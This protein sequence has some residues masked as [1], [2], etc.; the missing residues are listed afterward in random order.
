MIV[1]NSRENQKPKGELGGGGKYLLVLRKLKRQ[2]TRQL[3]KV[4]IEESISTN[5]TTGGSPWRISQN[6]KMT[7]KTKLAICLVASLG[8]LA[9]LLDG[10]VVHLASAQG[11]ALTSGATSN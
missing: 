1:Y 4:I 9:T 11:G 2:E 7:R 3:R 6:T 5:P 10:S 8:L